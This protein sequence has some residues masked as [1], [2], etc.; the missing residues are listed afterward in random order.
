[1]MPKLEWLG[2]SVGNFCVLWTGKGGEL[3]KEG[4]RSE[5]LDEKKRIAIRWSTE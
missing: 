1:M 4:E 3:G 5:R 2:A